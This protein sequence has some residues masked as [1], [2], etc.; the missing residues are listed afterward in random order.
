[1][2]SKQSSLLNG[3][4]SCESSTDTSTSPPS[5][6]LRAQ[7]TSRFSFLTSKGLPSS[8]IIRFTLDTR[9]VWA[10]LTFRG[11]SCWRRRKACSNTLYN[12]R[13]NSR[14]QLTW[15][16]T[17]HSSLPLGIYSHTKTYVRTYTKCK[18]KVPG[19]PLR[20]QRGLQVSYVHITNYVQI[21]SF[22]LCTGSQMHHISHTVK[23]ISTYVYTHIRTYIQRSTKY[24]YTY[25]HT[26]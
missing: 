26:H 23:Y 3:S 20:K 14:I 21:L 1:M 19:S 15:H 2:Q 17:P 18:P 24:V 22:H 11:K 13:H 7:I 16:P 5:S 12:I 4:W 25:I 8:S 9:T 10:L 6:V